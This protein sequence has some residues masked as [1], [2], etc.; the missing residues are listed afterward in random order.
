M[1]RP[2][3]LA[4]YIFLGAKVARWIKRKGWHWLSAVGIVLGIGINTA[5]GEEGPS[6]RITRAG[7][8]ANVACFKEVELVFWIGV[9]ATGEDGEKL[10]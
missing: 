7:D 1:I 6:R 8:V 2:N 5:D 3:E 4:R 9:H 10:E